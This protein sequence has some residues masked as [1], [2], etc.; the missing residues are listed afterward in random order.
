MTEQNEK[1]IGYLGGSSQ[2]LVM[3]ATIILQMRFRP[4][5]WERQKGRLQQEDGQW[6]ISKAGSIGVRL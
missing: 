5:I 6:L 3:T 4:W 2:F 1:G